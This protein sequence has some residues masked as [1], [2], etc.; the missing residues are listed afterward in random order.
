MGNALLL[1]TFLYVFV[2]FYLVKLVKKNQKEA[3]IIGK[4]KY[5]K[6]ILKAIEVLKLKRTDKK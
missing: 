1:Y 6:Y 2:V 3:G 5:I 4:Q